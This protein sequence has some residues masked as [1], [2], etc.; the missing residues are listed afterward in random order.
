MK[1]PTLND[2]LG[3]AIFIMAFGA[4]NTGVMTTH[5]L[6]YPYTQYR[7]DDVKRVAARL[8]TSVHTALL[9]TLP[10]PQIELISKDL[11]NYLSLAL[12]DGW[13]DEKNP[14]QEV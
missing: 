11:D 4:K 14:I 12:E 13:L 9:T 7:V 2:K 8:V 1:V 10:Q 3:A 6:M 5:K